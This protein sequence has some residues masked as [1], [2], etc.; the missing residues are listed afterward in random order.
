MGD[1]DVYQDD[2]PPNGGGRGPAFDLRL[3]RG[4]LSNLSGRGRDHRDWPDPGRIGRRWLDA[5]G[6][7]IGAAGTFTMGSPP[8]EPGHDRDEIQHQVTLTTSF[9]M[10]ATEVTNQQYADLAEWACSQ[11]YCAVNESSLLDA[12]DGSIAELLDLENDNCEIFFRFGWFYVDE[13]KEDH[14]VREVTWYGAVAYCDWLSLQASLPRAY[15]HGTWQ[16]NDHD[17]YNALGYRLPTEA[18]WEY[19]CRARSTTGFFYGQITDPDYN[20][21]VLNEIG[22]YISNSDD[23][24]HPVGQLIPNAWGLYDMHGNLYE[25]CNDWWEDYD[26]DVIDPVGHSGSGSHR[27]VRSGEWDNL[28]Q[29]CR[30]ANRW[31]LYAGGSQD[32]IG[33]R[34]VRSVNR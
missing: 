2:V 13:G 5:H 4:Q 32:N 14:P 28:A 15:D 23:S 22:W 11:G 31:R 10:S 26:G 21:P 24:T 8:N 20:D 18:E 30:S 27:V 17:P 19:A 29:F 33:F 7:E 12:L 16:C 9:E 1:D 6:P 34:P 3:Q 25:W